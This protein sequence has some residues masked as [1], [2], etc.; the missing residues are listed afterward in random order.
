MRNLAV[1][2]VTADEAIS[3]VQLALEHYTST[4][5]ARGIGDVDGVALVIIEKFIDDNKERFDIFSR[6]SLEVI[7][8]GS[9]CLK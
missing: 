2:P 8:E 4:I 5:K 7:S 9:Q 6:A 3:A 1:Y